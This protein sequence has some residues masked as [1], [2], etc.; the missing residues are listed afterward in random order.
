MTGLN[1]PEAE[2]WIFWSSFFTYLFIAALVIL[3]VTG[4]LVT[5]EVIELSSTLG[6]S[7]VA[8]SFVGMTVC[9]LATDLI[10][11]TKAS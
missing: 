11:N 6:L 9:G 4:G 5:L 7:L 1:L 8:V 2:E 10:G 3:G